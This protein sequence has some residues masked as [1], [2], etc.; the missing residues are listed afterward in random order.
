MGE[1]L[2]KRVDEEFR[3]EHNRDVR[4]EV[5]WEIIGTGFE[6]LPE[7]GTTITG[8]GMTIYGAITRENDVL[9]AGLAIAGLGAGIIGR[10]IYYNLRPSGDDCKQSNEKL[11][12]N[13]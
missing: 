3:R 1:E 10:R 2:E 12:N 9:A 8:I 11:I 5:I 13:P 4:D 6:M 7:V